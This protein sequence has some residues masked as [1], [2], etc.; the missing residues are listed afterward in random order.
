M[1]FIRL[2]CVALLLGMGVSPSV[3]ADGEAFNQY[4]EGAMAIYSKFKEPS[5]Q[6]SEQFYT[7]IKSKWQKET[8]INDCKNNGFRAGKEYAS[9]MNVEFDPDSRT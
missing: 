6:E 3:Q 7:F 5:K 4:V 2:V 9:V 1:A 8:C